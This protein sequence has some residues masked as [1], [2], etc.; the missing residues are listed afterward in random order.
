MRL[1]SISAFFFCLL[2]CATQNVLVDSSVSKSEEIADDDFVHIAPDWS[3]DK[4]IYQVN[5][6]QFS[7][8][9]NFAG[10]KRHLPRLKQMGIQVLYLMPVQPVGKKNRK[11]SQG[12]Y[13]AIQNYREVNPEFGT[14]AEL[15]SL[16]DDAHTLDMKVLFD[17][18]AAYSAADCNLVNEEASWYAKGK[19]SEMDSSEDR[20]DLV[21]FNYDKKALQE[22]MIESMAYWVNTCGIDGFRCH[23]AGSVPLK[24]WQKANRH[25]QNIKPLLMLG[26]TDDRAYLTDAF[27]ALYN[28]DLYDVMNGVAAGT[29]NLE[30]LKTLIDKQQVQYGANLLNYTSG[31][32]ENAEDGSAD[33]RMGDAAACFAH[34]INV[35]PGMP[36][37]YGG[38]EAAQEKSLAPYEKDLI[39]WGTFSLVGD[40]RIMCKAKKE[41]PAFWNATRSGSIE[42]L[43]T[44]DDEKVLAFLRR[45][46]E[47]TIVCIFNLSDE[48]INVK[49]NIGDLVGAFAGVTKRENR[50]L[51]SEQ[52][53]R[54]EP[55]ESRMYRKAQ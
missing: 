36:L 15:Q 1:F 40:Y 53:W 9:G 54:L 10:L 17:W 2:A 25:L 13:Y 4:W 51:R 45:T 18:S 16:I 38:Q 8:Q 47:Q 6:R 12:N 31:C 34:L 44:T 19:K 26:D 43:T 41:H 55:W 24:F 39:D 29:Q 7:E 5:I 14:L 33:Q 35:I 37:M 32:Q 42:W 23:E 49:V 20:S 21:K 50:S 22:Y 48:Q 28:Y 52:N 11:G 27:H 30:S 3:K 46:E